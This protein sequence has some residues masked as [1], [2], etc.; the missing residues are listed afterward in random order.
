[1]VHPWDCGGAVRTWLVTHTMAKA[2]EMPSLPAN[3]CVAIA[4][5]HQ[6]NTQTI[7]SPC[8]YRYRCIIADDIM[9]TRT[10]WLVRAEI[11]CR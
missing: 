10:W 1:M 5:K 7:M 9:H 11:K 8:Q 4:C 6:T 3:A 2:P